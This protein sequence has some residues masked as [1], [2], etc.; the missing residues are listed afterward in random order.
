[1][2][3][4]SFAWSNRTFYQFN[5]SILDDLAFCTCALDEG[6]DR[7][8]HQVSEVVSDLKSKMPELPEYLL[9]LIVDV[10]EIFV[11]A[12]IGKSNLFEVFSEC[13]MYPLQIG[14]RLGNIC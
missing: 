13:G 5:D 14:P 1:M 7:Q 9:L 11:I 10:K 12:R 6:I 4:V 2:E 3:K 8:V